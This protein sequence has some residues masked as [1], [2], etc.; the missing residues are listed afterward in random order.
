MTIEMWGKSRIKAT[1]HIQSAEKMVMT[2]DSKA[3][4]SDAPVMMNGQPSGQTMGIK[5]VDAHHTTNTVKWNGKKIGTSK[6]TLSPDGNTLTV[7]NDITADSPGGGK[8]K[9]TEVWVRK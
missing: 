8:G 3:D 6:G 9:T 5:L 1:Y 7:E 4:G 2:I